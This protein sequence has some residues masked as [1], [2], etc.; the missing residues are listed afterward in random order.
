MFIIGIEA[1]RRSEKQVLALIRQE[2]QIRLSELAAKADFSERNTLR[3][4][5]HLRAVNLVRVVKQGLH[6]VYEPIS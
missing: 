4:L 1:M 5:S 3:I 6:S 2:K